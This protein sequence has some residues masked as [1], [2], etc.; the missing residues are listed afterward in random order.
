MF[1]THTPKSPGPSP[2][3]RDGGF[4]LV[5]IVVVVTLMGMAAAFAVPRYTS[6]ANHTRASEVQALGAHLREAVQAAHA[7]YLAS[8]STLDAAQLRGRAVS[9]QN[10]Y[11]EATGSGIGNAIVDWGGFVTKTGP[12]TVTFFKTGAPADS[13]CSVT[14]KAAEPSAAGTITNIN[15]TGC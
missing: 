2:S 7:Q 13:E 3:R 10:G 15:I 9:L 14:Y 8:G 12:S 1:S 4:S 11:P 6:L 5:E